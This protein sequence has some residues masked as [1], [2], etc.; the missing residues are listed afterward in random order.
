MCIKIRPLLI[1]IFLFPLTLVGQKIVNT[2]GE[3]VDNSSI[4]TNNSSFVG[5][6]NYLTKFSSST[7]LGTSVLFE[8]ASKIGLNTSS[9]Y[10]GLNISGGGNSLS[11]MDGNSGGQYTRNQILFSWSGA[12]APNSYAHAIKTRHNNG[13]PSENAI[14]FYLWTTADAMGTIGTKHLMTLEGTGNVGIG[15]TS[16]KSKLEIDGAATNKQAASMGTATA[17]TFNGSNLAYTTASAGAFNLQYMKDGGTYTLAVQGATS[18]TSTFSGLNPNN[19]AFTFKYVN[20][21]TTVP[22]TH[23]LY[24]FIVMGTFVYVYMATGF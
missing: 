12:S 13:G 3:L 17:I 14:D 7:Q 9:L 24:T 2:A 22:N 23:T 5:T 16:P 18:G 11:L 8:N 10:A 21:G 6:A 4:F 19:T 20:N 1:G 15:T